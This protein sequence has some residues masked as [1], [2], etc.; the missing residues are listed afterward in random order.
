MAIAPLPF[1]PIPGCGE[2]SHGPCR[3]HRAVTHKRVDARRGSRH[4][5]GYGSHW[6]RFIPAFRQLLLARHIIPACGA[7]LSGI[8]SPRSRC[9]THGRVTLEGLHL[10]HDPPLETWERQHPARVCDPQRVGFLCAACHTI[11]TRQDLRGHP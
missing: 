2:R 9:A 5:R 1:C 3:T 10:D 7:R 4:V 11:A 8:P 6:V